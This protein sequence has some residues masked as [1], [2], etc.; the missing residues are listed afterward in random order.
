MTARTWRNDGLLLTNR[1]IDLSLIGM[2]ESAIEE[3]ERRNNQDYEY[4]D[5]YYAHPAFSRSGQEVQIEQWA[6]PLPCCQM[7]SQC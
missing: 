7:K 5:G 3:E 1:D 6:L 4:E 2:K